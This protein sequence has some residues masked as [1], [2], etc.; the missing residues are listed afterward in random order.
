MMNNRRKYSAVDAVYTL[1]ILVVVTVVSVTY[2]FFSDIFFESQSAV[3]MEEN[4]NNNGIVKSKDDFGL[5]DVNRDSEDSHFL[6]KNSLSSISCSEMSEPN[7]QSEYIEMIGEDIDISL[8][9]SASTVLSSYFQLCLAQHL[10]PHSIEFSIP[11]KETHC[12]LYFSSTQ[13]QPSRIAWDWKLTPTT[14]QHAHSIT[15]STL[16]KEFALN[17]DSGQYSTLHGTVLSTSKDAIDCTVSFK[18]SLIPMQE[19]I[20]RSPSLRGQVLLPR[21]IEK[22]LHPI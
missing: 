4:T 12:S 19:L 15:L 9:L 20:K 2:L 5:L 21:D 3:I 16:M 7:R 1:L 22:I 10:H 6:V 8:T 13:S 18:V 14:V 17:R 11:I